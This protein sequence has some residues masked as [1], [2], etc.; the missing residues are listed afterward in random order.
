[1]GLMEAYVFYSHYDYSDIWPLMFGQSEKYLSGKK[2]YLITNKVDNN[3]DDEWSVI[4]Y[5]DTKPYQRRV[6][7][8]LEKIDED[9]LIFHHED[10]F[11]LNKPDWETMSKLISIVEKDEIDLIKLTKASYNN[12]NHTTKEQNIFFNPADLLFSIQPTIIKKE[13]LI[14]I[15][16]HTKGDSI[17][18]FEANSNSLVYYLNY[19]SCYYHEGPEKKRGLFHWDSFV[20]PYIATA[21]VKGKWDYEAYP[22]E[23]KD[24]HDEYNIDPSSRGKNAQ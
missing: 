11:L 8:S 21:V 24:L 18:Q 3:I 23:L 17:W 13:K 2:K 7:E 14:K 9:V 4:L 12:E 6:F 15:Y 16:K 1:V 22:R 19:S 10:M 20:Y 5:D